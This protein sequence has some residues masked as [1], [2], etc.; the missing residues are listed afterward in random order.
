MVGWRWEHGNHFQTPGEV[1]NYRR[2]LKAVA[3]IRNSSDFVPNW[4]NDEKNEKKWFVIYDHEDKSLYADYN[5]S[6]QYQ[7]FAFYRTEEETKQAI[8]D[9]KEEYLIVFGV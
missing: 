4:D 6:R 3:K 9:L 5:F 2:Y 7:V 1:D 8:K